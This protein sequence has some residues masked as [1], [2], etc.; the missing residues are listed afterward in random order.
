MSGWAGEGQEEW[1]KTGKMKGSRERVKAEKLGKQ[2]AVA[3]WAGGI[4][5]GARMTVVGVKMRGSFPPRRPSLLLAATFSQ[6]PHVLTLM[7]FT[8][9]SSALSI[10][11]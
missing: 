1:R 5:A 8:A 9:A 6:F 7:G 11:K 3:S 4:G 10:T 2:K